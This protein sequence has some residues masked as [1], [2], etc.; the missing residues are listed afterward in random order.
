MLEKKQLIL[1][2]LD[3]TLINSS[4]D[5]AAAINH[6]LHTLGR[7]YVLEAEVDSWV[8]NGALMLVKRALSGSVIPSD[9][10]DETELEE[11][12]A[13]FLDYYGK[14][15]C[16]RTHCYTGVSETLE[17]LQQRGYIMVIVTNKPHAFVSPILEGLGIS[18]YFSAILGGDS[19]S[20]KK[21]DPLPLT[22]MM[23]DFGIALEACV[24]VGDSKNDILAARAAGME[25]IAVT[26]G[27]NYTE[28]ISF[29]QPDR[30]IETFAE[31]LEV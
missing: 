15:L 14:H 12:M 11:A 29:Y 9:Q 8:G 26:Y 22:Q 13:C 27:Y 2:D 31:I 23:T 30:I 10:L 28:P 20:R 17:Q 19:L 7:K 6:M 24:M 4:P 5:L 16:V 21:P 25:S 18:G 3:G 1:F